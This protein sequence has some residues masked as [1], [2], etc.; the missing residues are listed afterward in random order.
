[1]C[2]P[3]PILKCSPLGI[4]APNPS[5]N[6]LATRLHQ[7]MV[8]V[9]RSS[10]VIKQYAQL[11]DTIHPLTLMGDSSLPVAPVFGNVQLSNDTIE[12]M[13]KAQHDALVT[14]FGFCL[15]SGSYE[16]AWIHEDILPTA[17]KR[18]SMSN[19]VNSDEMQSWVEKVDCVKE[20]LEGRQVMLN[21]QNPAS[22]VP[23]V[24][25]T[26]Q[27]E[28]L[29]Q[30]YSFAL[31]KGPLSDEMIDDAKIRALCNLSELTGF[32]LN[33]TPLSHVN[34]DKQLAM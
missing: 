6:K 28:I 32:T 2:D 9:G 31:V 16:N 3:S 23:K 25:Y 13:E 8:A 20:A 11:S 5:F 29:T 21:G 22:Y 14:Y 30:Y 4:Y 17:L 18:S 7:L 12:H 19:P 33:T 34:H 27:G 10:R 26:A 15:L 1:M 24:V